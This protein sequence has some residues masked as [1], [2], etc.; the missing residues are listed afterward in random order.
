[1][2]VV[3]A[4]GGTG[5]HLYPAI[6]IADALRQRG[7]T[8]VF[9]GTQGRLESSIVP[10][11]GYTLY[12]IASQPLS[13]R[14]STELFSSGARNALGIIQSLRLLRRLQPHMVIATGGYVCFPVAVAARL[15]RGRGIARPRIV[16]LEPNASPGL[17]ARVLAPMAD[18]IWGE[19]GGFS[20]K[21]RAK[22]RPTGV[23]VR[24]RRATLPAREEAAAR[25]GFDAAM[26]T[27]LV[28]GGSQ[29][30]RSIND[31][32]LGL[33]ANSIL[34]SWKI[35]LVAGATDCERVRERAGAI[36]R[37][38]IVAYLDDMADAYAVADAIVARAG[39]STLAELRAL[40]IPAV[41][42]PYPHATAAHQ[43]ENALRFAAEGGAVVV[44]DRD[45][46]A[47]RLAAS[48]AEL[49][50]Q[51]ERSVAADPLDLVLERID[52]L[53]REEKRP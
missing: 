14:P 7:A 39:A 34:P 44:N 17:T 1:M 46:T 28:I 45:L 41:L 30:A 35:L 43:D 15:L 51:G 49:A 31:A 20:D 21:A 10:R 29:G 12:T 37:L 6:A 16:L 48:I 27:L 32:V 5:G 36:A 24:Y 50:E 40:A 13:R 18:E 23:P 11:A 3:F 22:C 53:A 47:E 8:V 2:T 42:V 38:R 33:A 4:G 26:K 19:C 52:A 25:L 9:V